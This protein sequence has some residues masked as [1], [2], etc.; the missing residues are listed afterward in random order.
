MSVPQ[1]G[2][3]IRRETCDCSLDFSKIR[4][5]RSRIR[6]ISLE[7]V[8]VTMKNLSLSAHNNNTINNITI[9]TTTKGGRRK[10]EG[11]KLHS[12]TGV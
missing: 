7:L 1:F 11:E 10:L 9:T 12:E 8:L 6:E 4:E 5:M 3:W 2:D